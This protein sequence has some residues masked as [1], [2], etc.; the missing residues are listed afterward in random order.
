M[1]TAPDLPVDSH[2]DGPGRP[3]PMPEPVPTPADIARLHRAYAPT[4]EAF[5][6]V[7][8]HCRIVWEIAERLLRNVP[9]A[10]IDADLVRAGCLL[11]D[12]GVYRLYDAEGRLDHRGYIRHGILG[13]E[14]L[15]EAGLPERICRFA[16]HHTGVGITRDD[17]CRQGLP[18][19]AADYLAVTAEERLVMYAD[20]FHSKSTP[21]RFLTLDAYRQRVRRFGPEK[22]VALDRLAEEF[23]EPADLD[24]LATA[25]DSA[26]VR[27]PG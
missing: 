4:S 23:G 21:P 27:S 10:D 13:H 14:I 16:S 3:A 19:P 8:T 12:V 6:S 1:T 20:K 24:A 17:V 18:I 5:D 25:Y 26:V 7:H 2:R 22:V 11:H 9:N 15:T